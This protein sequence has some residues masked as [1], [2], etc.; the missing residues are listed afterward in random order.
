ML[1]LF[2]IMVLGLTFSTLIH[3]TK[4]DSFDKY[5]KNPSLT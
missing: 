2:T 1:S 5:D 3:L 4:N